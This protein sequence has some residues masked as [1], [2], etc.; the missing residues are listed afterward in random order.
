MALEQAV[1][2]D[3]QDNTEFKHVSTDATQKDMAKVLGQSTARKS[4]E[5]RGGQVRL[6]RDP[7]RLG[8]D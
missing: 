4:R 5:A 2:Q 3:C 6:G 8:E 1:M 7:L